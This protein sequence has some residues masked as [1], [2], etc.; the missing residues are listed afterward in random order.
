M[1]F[2]FLCFI[3]GLLNLAALADQNR[4]EEGHGD[5]HKGHHMTHD[6]SDAEKWI[7]K[8]EDPTR[9]EWQKPDLVVEML[10]LKPGMNVADIGAASGY[11]TRRMARK[12]MPGGYALAV[13]I[14]SNFFPYV[15]ERAYKEQQFNLFTVECTETDPRLPERSLD[16]ILIV[17]TLHHIEN[18]P[19]YYELLKA[20]LRDGGRVVIVDFKKHAD[21]PVGPGPKMRLSAQ[22]VTDEFEAAGFQVS[23]DDNTLPYQYILTASL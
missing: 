11:F 5:S 14:E 20:S 23:V 21:I 3:I 22:S 4:H 17:D 6:F 19:T 9:D 16:L 18:R 13:E 2:L 12:I 15:L 10:N 7:E 1:R 8:F